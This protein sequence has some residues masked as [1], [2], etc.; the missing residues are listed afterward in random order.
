MSVACLLHT[1][2]LPQASAEASSCAG[3]SSRRRL[4][5]SVGPD[6]HEDWGGATACQYGAEPSEGLR[7]TLGGGPGE[8]LGSLGGVSRCAL[9]PF[10]RLHD[11]VL[12][13][14]MGVQQS[15]A[16]GSSPYTSSRCRR[17]LYR[18]LLALLLAPSPRCPPPLAC[19]LQAFSLG[20]REDSIEVTADWGHVHLL[21]LGF[22]FLM[23]V[24]SRLW[25][26]ETLHSRCSHLLFLFSPG[27]FFLLGGPGDLCYFDPPPGSSS[28]V[29]GPHLPHPCPSSSS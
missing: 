19:A 1:V 16:L 4:T 5:G 9:C 25:Y 24:G 2:L 3:L 10:Q 17:E 12:P 15:E 29:H 27:L 22:S 20:Q 7:S 21:G 28:A 11:L 18:L 23:L 6:T 8:G 26:R 14:V 13:L